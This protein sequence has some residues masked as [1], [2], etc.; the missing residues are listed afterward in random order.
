[1][2]LCV[3][4]CETHALLLRVALKLR[5][6][7]PH[8]VAERKMER[9]TWG[10]AEAEDVAVMHCELVSEALRLLSEYTLVALAVPQG[11]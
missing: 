5:V 6:A 7:E 10:V 8:G 4:V 3:G 1:M 9:D 11:E 2:T